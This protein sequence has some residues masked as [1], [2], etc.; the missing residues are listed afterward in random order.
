MSQLIIRKNNRLKSDENYRTTHTD[1]Y[2]DIN[3]NNLLYKK[4]PVIIGDFTLTKPMDDRSVYSYKPKNTN[5]SYIYHGTARSSEV[6]ERARNEIGQ[7][8]QRISPVRKK[9]PFMN[10][11][12]HYQS[13]LTL[14]S[15]Q[16]RSAT[17]DDLLD[18]HSRDSLYESPPRRN[19]SCSSLSTG[20]SPMVALEQHNPYYFGEPQESDDDDDEVSSEEERCI[21]FGS[22]SPPKLSPKPFIRNSTFVPPLLYYDEQFHDEIIFQ[23]VADVGTSTDDLLVY[24]TLHDRREVIPS[25]SF[26]SEAGVY[27]VSRHEAEQNNY[28]EPDTTL[29]STVKQSTSSASSISSD[30]MP[31]TPP[32]TNPNN[33]QQNIYVDQKRNDE[34]IFP[35]PPPV[36][37]SVPPFQQLAREN[38]VAPFP[39]PRNEYVPMIREPESSVNSKSVKSDRSRRGFFNIFS[40]KKN[41]NDDTSSKKSSNKNKKSKS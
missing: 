41:K 23:E 19:Q 16:F 15:Q 36:S 22:Q 18:D 26:R 37:E 20:R 31:P 28:E 29:F 9:I 24:S 32:K 21:I 14:P 17:D 10:H 30:S 38:P 39:A 25:P 6:L 12:K 11:Q 5:T 35:P 7:Y 33:D 3:Q 13:M 4:Y 27:R 1:H 2:D 8:T 34:P 40:R